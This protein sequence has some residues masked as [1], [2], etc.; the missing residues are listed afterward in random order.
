MDSDLK[1][2][3]LRGIVEIQPSATEKEIKTTHQQNAL[4]CHPDEIPDNSKAA[5]SFSTLYKLLT[6]LEDIG[7]RLDNLK[8]LNAKTAE[9]T[10]E[11]RCDLKRKKQDKVERKS[12]KELK[13]LKKEYLYLLA[14]V[15]TRMNKLL[16][17]QAI[18]KKRIGS[19]KL[20]VKWMANG[21]YNK[22]NLMSLFSKYG[23]VINVVVL[24]DKSVALVEYK[25]KT[26][27]IN[28][29]QFEVGYPNCPLT[30]SFLGDYGQ[31]IKKNSNYTSAPNPS[32]SFSAYQNSNDKSY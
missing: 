19:F 7:T 21:V 2:L 9:E 31:D 32:T 13:H 8:K 5:R 30:V 23:H 16:K 26:S 10:Q 24:E 20:K 4:Q 14:T 6:I 25:L 22:D 18:D 29:K 27:A 1:D 17:N 12:K 15:R 28:A 11:I 3:D